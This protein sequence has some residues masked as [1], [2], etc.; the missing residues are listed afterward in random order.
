V[1]TVSL[2]HGIFGVVQSPRGLATDRSVFAESCNGTSAC[3]LTGER[4]DKK[5][6]QIP[7]VWS[8]NLDR[9][10]LSRSEIRASGLDDSSFPVF[11]AC[12]KVLDCALVQTT[13]T[14]QGEVTL[15]LFNGAWSVAHLRDWSKQNP[16]DEVA[17]LATSIGCSDVGEC[18][19]GLDNGTG[20]ATGHFPA[21][22]LVE[23]NGVW[24]KFKN[25]PG[26][27]GLTSGTNSGVEAVFCVHQGR[28]ILGG[29]YAHSNSSSALNL[30]AFLA[31][32]DPRYDRPKRS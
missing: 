18:V 2:H 31:E 26:T 29:Y 15:D 23:H 32:Y 10:L 19:V 1:Y 16:Y 11:V 22:M 28:C 4:V 9:D 14:G 7:F 27:Y 3:V 17:Q 30:Q 8:V 25:V 13:D 12:V 21:F 24:T 6:G 5:G 20:W